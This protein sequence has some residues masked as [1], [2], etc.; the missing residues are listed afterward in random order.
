MTYAID[1]DTSVQ[2][3]LDMLTYKRPAGSRTEAEFITK[4]LMPFDPHI[5]GFG[6][7]L[8]QIGENPTIMWSSH[9]DSVHHSDGRQELQFHGNMVS[10]KVEKVPVVRKGKTE[11]GL[12]TNCLGADCAA[13]VWL[14]MEMMK[15][16]VPG[17]YI[18]HREEEI[19][20][21]GSSFIARET[22]EILEGIRFAIAF[23]RK[24]YDSVI[25]H[26]GGRTASDAFAESLAAILGGVFKPDPT[27]LFT[28]TA[29]YTGLIAECSNVSVGYFAAHGPTESLD[30]EFL[31]QL[32]DTL[33]TADFSTLVEERKPAPKR[34]W[35]DEED[36][37]HPY[38]GGM[39]RF[40]FHRDR[41]ETLED[42]CW[43]NT[44]V[45][46]D[47]LDMM[48]ITLED[49]KEYADDNRR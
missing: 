43:N 39:G 48:G 11:R 10:A 44:G 46:A 40:S 32:R 23:D 41:L 21:N 12:S 45:V 13:G 31:R 30:I 42:F 20:G 3:L 9:T 15:A 33:I 26:Q 19:G 18:F 2:V 25:T 47:F 24:G 29:N 17:L 37:E 1:T 5:D 16:G 28:D 22:P 36:D 38:G 14:M 34:A 7:L 8:I 49:L 4:F 35:W 6:N 27:G